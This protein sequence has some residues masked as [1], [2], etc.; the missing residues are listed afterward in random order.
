VRAVPCSGVALNG[1]VPVQLDGPGDAPPVRRGMPD[2][3]ACRWEASGVRPVV[4]IVSLI[5]EHA[6]EVEHQLARF[7]G[8]RAEL[9]RLCRPGAEAP[10]TT[11]LVVVTES[12]CMQ[13]LARWAPPE[14][15]LMP[16]TWTLT[17]QSV[18]RIAELPSGSRVHVACRTRGR[19]LEC[20]RL[21]RE[22]LVHRV[23]L[24]P[25]PEETTGPAPYATLVMEEGAV[26]LSAPGH[27]VPIRRV[28]APCTVMEALLALGLYD[29]LAQRRLN[30]YAA[31]VLPL[32]CDM[33]YVTARFYCVQQCLRQANACIGQATVH[34]DH[35]RRIFLAGGEVVRLLERP[36]HKLVGHRVDPL[37]HELGVRASQPAERMTYCKGRLI[38]VRVQSVSLRRRQP[39]G[40]LTMREM[41]LGEC[42][43]AAHSVAGRR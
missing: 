21:L 4:A 29:E 22:L 2:M 14:A 19:A 10:S 38:G 25:A 23:D 15:R 36:V 34:F 13:W 40:V 32:N 35:R 17:R 43:H 31:G 7:I 24:R 39:G 1:L 5:P 16:A 28:L 3:V 33:Q 8:G 37:L 30:R 26:P 42:D 12:T 11:E 20:I 41:T 18:R 6:A 9:R 27:V